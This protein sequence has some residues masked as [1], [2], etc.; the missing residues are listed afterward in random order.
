MGGSQRIV[1]RQHG[2]ALFLLV[3]M[4]SFGMIEFLELE[5]MRA[6]LKRV[7]SRED[8]SMTGDRPRRARDRPFVEGS[9]PGECV[10]IRGRGTL[11]TVA[12]QMIRPC[13]VQDDQDHVVA[14]A[15][16]AARRR[17]GQQNHKKYRA[18]RFHGVGIKG[19]ETGVRQP[20]TDIQV[21]C[22]SAPP[23]AILEFEILRWKYNTTALTRATEQPTPKCLMNHE[24]IV[25]GPAHWSKNRSRRV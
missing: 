24:T 1:D 3:L 13:G 7:L 22:S 17:Q 25:R 6:V 5:A 11:V 15:L 19:W 12:A 10:D 9:P 18:N 8:R 16:I 20:A 2:M 23:V 14:R 21:N 4:K